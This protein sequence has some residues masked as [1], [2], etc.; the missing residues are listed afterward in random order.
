MN[1]KEEREEKG[2]R[3]E[4]VK[5]LLDEMEK[6]EGLKVEESEIIALFLVGSRGPYQCFKED[7]DWDFLMILENNEQ[8]KFKKFEYLRKLE[9]KDVGV[10]RIDYWLEEVMRHHLIWGIS[11]FFYEKKR[12]EFIWKEREDYKSI[13]KLNFRICHSN[14]FVGVNNEWKVVTGQIKKWLVEKKGENRKQIRKKLLYLQRSFLF[15]LQI[16]EKGKIFNFELEEL[17][18]SS[19]LLNNISMEN[20]QQI[21]EKFLSIKV[22]PL[23]LKLD[24]WAFSIQSN[25]LYSLP[26]TL[27]ASRSPFF[28]LISKFFVEGG[29]KLEGRR[30]KLDLEGRGLHLEKDKVQFEGLESKGKEKELEISFLPIL[31]EELGGEKCFIENEWR[32]EFILEISPFLAQFSSFHSPHLNLLTSCLSPFLFISSKSK[33][34]N[35]Q[36]ET[37]FNLLSPSFSLIDLPFAENVKLEGLDFCWSCSTQRLLQL[38]EESTQVFERLSR[39]SIPF[40]LFPIPPSYQ[41]KTNESQS[42]P[43]WILSV[44]STNYVNKKRKVGRLEGRFLYSFKPFSELVCNQTELKKESRIQANTK[45]DENVKKIIDCW[46][47]RNLIPP[48]EIPVKTCNLSFHFLFLPKEEK[49]EQKES[50]QEQIGEIIILRVFN[51]KKQAKFK[52]GEFEE[53]VSLTNW[54]SRKPICKLSSLLN[55]PLPKNNQFADEKQK[56]KAEELILLQIQEKLQQ[57]SL[58]R[59]KNGDNLEYNLKVNS[60]KG[61]FVMEDDFQENFQIISKKEQLLLRISCVRADKITTSNIYQLILFQTSKK[62]FETALKQREE[63]SEREE[64]DLMEQFKFL[65]SNLSQFF[66]LIDS[67]VSKINKQIGSESKEERE[68]KTAQSIVKFPFKKLLFIIFHKQIS[69]RE[70]FL[71]NTKFLSDFEKKWSKQMKQMKQMSK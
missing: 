62:E 69:C 18:E 65:E 49:E 4:R 3:K 1:E 17:E 33:E 67:I 59:N 40:T 14:L 60:L 43:E 58:N 46:K 7:S 22:A 50:F 6:K 52:M 66:C 24:K 16:F 20:W 47:K 70:V 5:E 45:F 53:F 68:K 2:K 30:L 36:K 51:L 63:H 13:L 32:E 23:L 21:D 26:S 31:V 28:Q 71:E 37:R 39:N 35:K 38:E 41:N 9:N 25:L 34:D 19:I 61:C 42:Q 56:R 12:E 10:Y 64:K 11:T 15:A 8:N 27:L 57:I 54:K 48:N 29:F 44:Y 55:S